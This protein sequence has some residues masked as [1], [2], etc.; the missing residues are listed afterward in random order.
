MIRRPPRST[1]FPYTTLFRSVPVGGKYPG[2]SPTPPAPRGV[3]R[4]PETTQA[5]GERGLA[6]PAQPPRAGIPREPTFPPRAGEGFDPMD[7]YL[8]RK[9]RPMTDYAVPQNATWARMFPGEAVR[10]DIAAVIDD[11]KS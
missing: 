7:P 6:A 10:K 2:P 9:D 8:S 4:L 1:L 5:P 11:R 3:P